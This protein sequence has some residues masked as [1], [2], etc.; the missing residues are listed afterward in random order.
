MSINKFA[1]FAVAA[2]T[3]IVASDTVSLPNWAAGAIGAMIAGFAS[4]GIRADNPR[5]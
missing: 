4:V 3:F 5:L 1:T 2:G